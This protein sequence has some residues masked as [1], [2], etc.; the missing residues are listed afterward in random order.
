MGLG[1]AVNLGV[2]RWWLGERVWRRFT[3]AAWGTRI[4][5]VGRRCS[6][7]EETRLPDTGENRA[8]VASGTDAVRMLGGRDP[9]R[10]WS[11]GDWP[12]IMVGVGD[13]I[14]LEAE[15]WIAWCGSRG[16]AMYRSS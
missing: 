15:A 11:I 1:D 3:M 8:V 16:L 7:L 4:V 10:P 2:N 13:L 9:L 12:R 6:P 14:V 5:G